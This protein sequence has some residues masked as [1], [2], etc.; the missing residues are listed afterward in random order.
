MHWKPALRAG[1]IELKLLPAATADEIAG[2]FQDEYLEGRIRVF[3]Y[4]GHA[5]GDELWLEGASGGNQSFSS[6]GLSRF[7]GAQDSLEFVFLNGCATQQHADLLLNAGIPSVL[8]TS[9]KINDD[10]ARMFSDRFYQGLA[11]GAHLH[12]AFVEGE[13]FILG[14][15][16][17]VQQDINRGLFW[18]KKE[19]KEKIQF[20]WR[21][22]HMESEAGRQEPSSWR[23]FGGLLHTDEEISEAE[24]IARAFIGQ[25]FG[26]YKVVKLLGIGSKGMVFKAVHETFHE[27]SCY[28]NHT[29]DSGRI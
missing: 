15:T 17:N 7:L 5:D 8:V 29:P 20:P 21:M 22:F 25:V 11:S 27:R 4:A 2:A 23:L 24:A 18:K 14:N 1:K 28:Q 3:H 16:Q 26:N 10:Q 12:E 6:L 13:A 19:E 9:E